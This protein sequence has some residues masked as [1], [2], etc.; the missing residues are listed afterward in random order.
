VEEV[1]NS[2]KGRKTLGIA[3]MQQ[4]LEML[5]GTIQFDSSLGRGTKV[6]AQIPTL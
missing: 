3:T 6:T 1:V 4:R 2:A 5:G